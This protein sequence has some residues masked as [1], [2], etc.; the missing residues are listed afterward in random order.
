M[1]DGTAFDILCG[2][3][4]YL[5]WYVGGMVYEKNTVCGMTVRGLG[6]I[7][8]LHFTGGMV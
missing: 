2:K 4:R 8:W 7:I 5:I 3:I 6:S 1:Y